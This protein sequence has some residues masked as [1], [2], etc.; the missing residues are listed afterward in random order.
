[1]FGESSVFENFPAPHFPCTFVFLLNSLLRVIKCR[2]GRDRIGGMETLADA[3]PCHAD[4]DVGGESDGGFPITGF[5]PAAVAGLL[6]GFDPSGLDAE[7]L[8]AVLGGLERVVAAAHAVQARVMAEFTP[9]P[10]GHPGSSVREVRRRRDRPGPV[11]D[12]PGGGEPG[13]SGG[14]DDHPNPC[15]PARAG[16]WGVGPVPGHGD[17]RRHLPPG[18]SGC[19]AGRNPRREPGRGV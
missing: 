6:T 3:I 14:G 1:L 15:G 11:D 12:P 4:S 5:D 17:H 16:V 7:S 2:G 18:R 10:A 9:A 13:R 8:L 19:D